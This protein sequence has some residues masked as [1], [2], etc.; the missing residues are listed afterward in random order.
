MFHHFSTQDDRLLGSRL[1]DI[2]LVARRYVF[3]VSAFDFICKYWYITCQYKFRV[4]FAIHFAFRFDRRENDEPTFVPL[5]QPSI[6]F[7][8]AGHRKCNTCAS[9]WDLLLSDDGPGVR[10]SR[11]IFMIAYL[12]S[13]TLHTKE[14][15][16]TTQAPKFPLMKCSLVT[17]IL[18]S[19]SIML[20]RFNSLYQNF[21]IKHL[22]A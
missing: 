7:L 17:T 21:I 9:I 12:F 8:W 15:Y 2:E 5:T 11:L 3:I 4:S 10:Q 22:A 6:F 16:A 20:L 13:L 19:T 1:L 18:A 14:K